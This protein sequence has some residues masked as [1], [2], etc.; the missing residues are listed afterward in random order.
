MSNN[1]FRIV[2]RQ[3]NH[4]IQLKKEVLKVTVIDFPWSYRSKDIE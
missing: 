3:L 1:R 2:R 4:K